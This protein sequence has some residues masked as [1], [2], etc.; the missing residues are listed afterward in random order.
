M[1]Q[2]TQFRGLRTDIA[3][4]DES[5]EYASDLQNVEISDVYGQV[6]ASTGASKLIDD[7]MAAASVDGIHDYREKTDGSHEVIAFCD[8]DM[9]TAGASTWTEITDSGSTSLNA[10]AGS[11]VQGVNIQELAFFVNGSDHPF[12]YDGS[13]WSEWGAEP[14][15]RHVISS[16][17]YPYLATANGSNTTTGRHELFYTFYSSTTTEESAPSGIMRVDVTST[18]EQITVHTGYSADGGTNLAVPSFA[19]RIRVYMTQADS[20]CTFYLA[21]THSIAGSGDTEETPVV[22]VADG[23]LTTAWEDFGGPPESAFGVTKIG[24]ELARLVVW[25]SP[26]YPSRIWYTNLDQPFVFGTTNWIDFGADDGDRIQACAQPTTNAVLICKRNA[27][28]TLQGSGPQTWT[29]S[30]LDDSI[31]C[32]ARYSMVTAQGSAYWITYS[33]VYASNGTSVPQNIAEGKIRQWIDTINWSQADDI[34]GNYV[35]E[36]EQIWWSVPYGSSQTT[37]NK[38]LVLDLRTME[39]LIRSHAV[40][41]MATQLDSGEFSTLIGTSDGY[42]LELDDSTNDWN[43]SAQTHTWESQWFYTGGRIHRPIVRHDKETSGSLTV[44]ITGADSED[45]TARTHST[46]VDLSSADTYSLPIG[47]SE[48]MAKFKLTASTTW[49]V[50]RAE[51]PVIETG[52]VR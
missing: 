17:T 5:I 48:R 22:D 35:S 34:R 27:T 40:Y 42:V 11:V 20:P 29:S 26:S 47:T 31:G 36:H 2:L 16:T 18:T 37:P 25:G 6:S 9:Y 19:D 7:Q 51:I 45:G 39:F 14:P 12:Y 33:G 52:K 44:T 46:T 49:T 50:R 4:D 21:D 24:A 38:V 3:P 28:W 13:D 15:K 1:I 43:G 23:S 41:A 30:P 32:A 8:G 10:T